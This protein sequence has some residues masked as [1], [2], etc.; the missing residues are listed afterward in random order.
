[1]A[2]ACE[3]VGN[4]RDARVLVS[5]TNATVWCEQQF[6]YTLARGARRRTPQM[7]RGTAVHK[8]LEEQ[9]HTTV[10]VT[11][12]TREDRWG[13]KL[14]NM[15]QGVA[16]LADKGL[17]RELPVFGFLDGVFVQGIV[18]EVSYLAPHHRVADIEARERL[19][20]DMPANEAD[21]V[22]PAPDDEAMFKVPKPGARVAFVSDTKTRASRS[23]P[24]IS[25]A[26]ATALQLMLYR[27]LLIQLYDGEV[28]FARVLD[29]FGVDGD[30]RF[31][32][33][34]SSG[35]RRRQQQA[36]PRCVRRASSFTAASSRRRRRFST[37]RSR[38][39]LPF[40]Q[41]RFAHCRKH[42][43]DFIDTQHIA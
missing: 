19:V 36:R 32:Y 22:P 13:L 10:A 20:R 16:C 3:I 40:N 24:T 38:I 18:D 17:T 8:L 28:D 33:S 7:E 6:E 42:R 11:A 30:A 34:S 26:R 27:R 37:R 43:Y 29:Q 21:F 12:A 25:Q 39:V 5:D 41:R 35:F 15:L 1:M 9:V 23:F 31:S 4:E 2:R 14:F